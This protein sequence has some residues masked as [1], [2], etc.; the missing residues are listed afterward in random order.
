[1]RSDELDPALAA[2]STLS[3]AAQ[4]QRTV[5]PLYTEDQLISF[6]NLTAASFAPP[7]PR[8]PAVT[9][10]SSASSTMQDSIPVD[11]ESDESDAYIPVASTSTAA[12]PAAPAPSTSAPAN[13]R[14]LR[15][16][17]PSGG[18][19]P[20]SSGAKRP[21]PSDC[22]PAEKAA[23]RKERNRIAAQKSRDKRQLEFDLV[24][25][26]RDKWRMKGMRLEQENAELKASFER[27]LLEARAEWEAQ[28]Q[29]PALPSVPAPDVTMPPSSLNFS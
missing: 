18:A 7:A 19:A 5:P 4:Q 24:V 10:T 16:L 28:A 17:V 25:A 2:L 8:P 14:R 22:S 6:A 23:L 21:L 1:M 29:A 11:D 9:T 3:H 13:K 12:D 15:S 27:R 20:S 26:D